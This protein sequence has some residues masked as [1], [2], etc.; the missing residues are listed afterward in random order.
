MHPHALATVT[1]GIQLGVDVLMALLVAVA[2]WQGVAS[3]EGPRRWSALLL[4]LAFAATYA[5]GRGVRLAGPAEP[6]RRKSG[7]ARA[8][9]WVTVLVLLWAGMLAI[10][11]VALWITFPLML[12]QMQVLGAHRGIPAVAATTLVAV[13]DATVVHPSDSFGAVLGP[14][15]GAAVAVT[16]VSGFHVLQR[17]VRTRQ[18]TLDELVSARSHLAAAE[19]ERVVSAERERLAREIHDTIAQDLS[20]AGLLLGAAQAGIGPD[21]V[22]TADLVAQAQAAV[23]DSLAQA[24][25]VVYELAP[26][27]LSE[28]TLVSALRRAGER[29]V[30]DSAERGIELDVSVVTQTDVPALPVPVETAVL[31]VAQSALANVVQHAG[32]QNVQVFLAVDDDLVVLDVVDDGVGFDPAH[33]DGRGPDHGFGLVA[34]RS[35]V[36]EI[37]GELAVESAPGA[38]AAV[39]VSVPVTSGP[40]AR[41]GAVA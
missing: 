21:D 24:R 12:V 7:L 33:L 22:R 11:P 5:W 8:T 2:T 41:S 15:V 19:R 13:V 3:E 25:R 4:G 10:S 28:G 16:A 32:A 39:S 14:L 35:R 20:A 29:A 26:A 1:R 18:E 9:V 38:G 23:A 6:L 30:R 40:V 37:G 31:R 34:M 27:E 17:E 36:T